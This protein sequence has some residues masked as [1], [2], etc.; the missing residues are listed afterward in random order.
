[1]SAWTSLTR[2]VRAERWDGSRDSANR[3]LGL[4]GARARFV[5]HVGQDD[6]HL[7]LVGP[8]GAWQLVELGHHVVVD[9]LLD[10]VLAVTPS[11]FAACFEARATADV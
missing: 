2:V 6:L 8:A 5:K 10:A 7:M 11:A 4:V 1:M 3:I 9:D